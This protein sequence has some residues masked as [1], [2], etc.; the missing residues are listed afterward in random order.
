MR[1]EFYLRSRTG[2]RASFI[3]LMFPEGRDISDPL[4]GKSESTERAREGTSAEGTPRCA[5]RAHAMR[6]EL[7]ASKQN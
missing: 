3:A 4:P 6:N 2:L 5:S 1:N 7:Q